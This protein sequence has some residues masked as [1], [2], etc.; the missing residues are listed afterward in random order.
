[1]NRKTIVKFMS[2]WMSAMIVV[3]GLMPFD[4]L[5]ASAHAAVKQ[6]MMMTAYSFPPGYP[7]L[8][9]DCDDIDC[10]MIEIQ[11]ERVEML[12]NQV[13]EK[14]DNIRLKQK[15][16]SK[17]EKLFTDLNDLHLS[18]SAD[19]TPETPIPSTAAGFKE[20][21]IRA[22]VELNENNHALGR[23]LIKIRMKQD[24]ESAVESLSKK[25]DDYDAEIVQDLLELQ[26]LREDLQK[27]I[28]ILDGL[29]NNPPF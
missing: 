6:E 25:I 5:Y 14:I 7:E 17:L 23:S 11:R 12:Q 2:V 26:K 20:D 18:F 13:N 15:E 10:I 4:S 9:G 27:E 8:P 29:L 21:I 1:M 16:Y 3:S 28:E 24:I 22:S 19:S